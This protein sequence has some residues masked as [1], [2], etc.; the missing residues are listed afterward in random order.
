R[1]R[2]RDATFPCARVEERP[3]RRRGAKD[4]RPPRAP[5][6]EGRAGVRARAQAHFARPRPFQSLRAR[7]APDARESETLRGVARRLRRRL[8]DERT[9]RPLRA[10]VRAPSV[11][12]R[13]R[14]GAL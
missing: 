11:L 13:A 8:R 9:R 2:G 12:L 7:R 10:G 4:A 6:P 14:E 3:T 1:R 5:G